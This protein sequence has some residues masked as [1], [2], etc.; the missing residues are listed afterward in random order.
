MIGANDAIDPPWDITSM[1]DYEGELG[2]VIGRG[3]R[4]IARANCGDHVWL[5]GDQ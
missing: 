2:V 4:R 3:G 1:V 5:Y